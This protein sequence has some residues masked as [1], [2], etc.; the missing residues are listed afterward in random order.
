MTKY[1]NRREAGQIL[2]VHLEK[3]LRKKELTK[4][5][6]LG[7]P[8]GGV[9][10]AFEVAAVLRCALDVIVTRK[11]GVPGHAELAC[12]AIGPEGVEILD[13]RLVSECGITDKQISDIVARESVELTRRQEL[14]RTGLGP[15]NLSGRDVILVDDG[16]ATGAT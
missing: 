15:L 14:Y 4:P 3:E 7:L 16:I 8:R 1:R 13:Q 10:V 5:L 9:P 6:V 12:G 2:G 11:L